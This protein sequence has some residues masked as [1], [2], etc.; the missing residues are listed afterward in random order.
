MF[1]PGQIIN[2]TDKSWGEGSYYVYDVDEEQKKYLLIGNDSTSRV[3][4]VL[5]SAGKELLSKVAKVTVL[6]ADMTKWPLHTL[7]AVLMVEYGLWNKAYRDVILNLE[8]SNNPVLEGQAPGKGILA[9][10]AW[11]K[12]NNAFITFREHY[13][14]PH[15][16]LIVT[17]RILT[18]RAALLAQRIL[19]G[20]KTLSSQGRRRLRRKTKLRN[21]N[22]R[23]NN[24][25]SKTSY[26]VGTKPIVTD[27]ATLHKYHFKRQHSEPD[28]LSLDKLVER[29]KRNAKGKSAPIVG[30]KKKKKV[31]KKPIPF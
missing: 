20:Q 15:P 2:A 16:N 5:F 6:P 29:E 13:A 25:P 12:Y 24:N 10:T 22:N 4:G 7:Y 30:K 14:H 21:R 27:R 17:K 28:V 31:N 11:Q 3:H 26:L 19:P 8:A 9:S 1:E 18:A 23:Y